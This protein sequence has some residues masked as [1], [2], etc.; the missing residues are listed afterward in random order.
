[1]SPPSE[2]AVP[3]VVSEAAEYSPHERQLLLRLAHE[4]I[5]AAL[6]G[7]SVDLNPPNEHLAEGRGAFTTLHLNGKLR[8][9]IGYVFPTQSLYCTVAETARSAAFDDPRFNPV[10]ADEAPALKIEISVLSPLRPIKPEEVVLGR[11]GLVVTYGGRRGLLLPQV[12][13]EWEW[14]RT[15]FLEQ[16]CLKAG[17]PPDAWLRGAELHAFSA[18]IFSEE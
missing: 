17:L 14:D 4:A 6:Q 10:K 18:E 15:T 7:R 8:G 5:E 16:T 13:I 3:R 2:N 1:M 11:H 9:C 12:P